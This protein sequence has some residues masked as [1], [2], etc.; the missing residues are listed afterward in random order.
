MLANTA[1]DSRDSRR[2]FTQA[3]AHLQRMGLET[4]CVLSGDHAVQL[5]FYTGCASR[6]TGGPD[7]S[8]SPGGLRAAAREKS[9]AVLA[10]PSAETPAVARSW[11]HAMLPGTSRFGGYHVYSPPTAGSTR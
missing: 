9:V 6:Q 10:P 11:R 5:S 7:E 3:A 8:I 4:P 1:A 2:D